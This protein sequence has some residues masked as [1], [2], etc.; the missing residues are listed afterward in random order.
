MTTLKKI[1]NPAQTRVV[2]FMQAANAY[3]DSLVKKGEKAEFI[4][5]SN[6][7]E[8]YKKIIKAAIALADRSSENHNKAFNSIKNELSGNQESLNYL[9]SL[10]ESALNSLK[11]LARSYIESGESNEGAVASAMNSL[12]GNPVFDYFGN[13]N[14]LAGQL[15]QN[16]AFIESFISHGDAFAVPTESGG[17][18]TATSRFRA[19][20]ERVMGAAKVYQGDINPQGY[21]QYDANGIQHSVFNEFK[22]ALTLYAKFSITQDQQNQILG[23]QKSIAPALAGFML[24]NRYFKSAQEQVLKLAEVMFI[25]GMD[26]EGTYKESVGGSYGLL[27]SA[28]LAN[29]SSWTLASPEVMSRGDWDS[30]RSK[31][32]QKIQNHHTTLADNSPLPANAGTTAIYQDIVRLFNLAAQQSVEYSSSGKWTLYVPTSFYAPAVQY[33]TGGTFNKQLIEMVKSAVGDK[34]VKSINIVPSALLDFRAKNNF[35]KKQW[36]YMIAVAHGA[37][38]ERKPVIMPGQ[39]AVPVVVS[40]NV[41]SQLMNFTCQYQF[42]GPMVMQYGGVYALEFSKVT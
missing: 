8:I 9:E 38:N 5:A 15:Y 18:G 3:A 23:Y 24:Q 31:L 32:I 1:S 11:T 14:L 42:G 41:S 30:N 13:L 37:E 39:T 27:S 2:N 33:P 6:A 21:L 16:K 25:D 35:G 22:N 40:D 17:T 12:A 29:N 34:I 10:G 36:N 7:K 28:I 19:P 4:S 20:S 26:E